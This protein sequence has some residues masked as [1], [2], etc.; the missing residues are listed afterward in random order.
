M[1]NFAITG[2]AGYVAP[3][4]LQAIRDT[5][6]R[7]VAAAD[8]HDSVGILD[9]YFADV[10]YF[11]EFERFDRHL[12]KLRRG[13][14]SERVHW[15]TVCA[16]NH[17]HD[18]HIRLALRVDAD[19]LCEKPLVLNPWN[20]DALAELE[21][22][23]GRR[24]FTVLQLRVHPA[25]IE[26]KKRLE[27]GDGSTRHAV[28]LTYVTGRGPWYRYAWKGDPI[29]SGGVATNIGIHFFDLLMWLFGSASAAEVHVST[30]ERAAGFLE[31][32]RADVTWF[33]SIDPADLP[34]E[35]EP[36]QPATFRSVTVD[37]DEVEFSG[38]FTDLHA[39]VYRET[40][41]GRGFGIED[42]RPSV[43]LAHRIRNATPTAGTG[44]RHEMARRVKS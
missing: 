15:L 9:R 25:L 26:L 44:P 17:L 6:N 42:A 10:A 24:V 11:T 39:L 4:H 33:L 12:E 3:R 41:E 37:G 34:F 32:E 20:L 18:A 31:L 7:L 23:S 22:E 29:R 19:A 30:D 14:D 8:P 16:P 35:P 21:R 1:N 2:V 13:P 40:L 36:G 27:A 43:E 38:G 28:N 5:G